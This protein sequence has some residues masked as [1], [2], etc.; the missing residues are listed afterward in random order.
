MAN[1]H[2]QCD[3]TPTPSCDYCQKLNRC[4]LR[5]ALCRSL[6]YAWLEGAPA[7]ECAFVEPVE[8]SYHG[9]KGVKA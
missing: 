4:A 2:Q 9:V 5:G 6:I 1:A 3:P 8:F 7:E